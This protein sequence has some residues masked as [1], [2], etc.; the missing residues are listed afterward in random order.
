MHGL[1]RNRATKH[2]NGIYYYLQSVSHRRLLPAKRVPQ[3]F[4][5]LVR[6]LRG[7]RGQFYR[8]AIGNVRT[9]PTVATDGVTEDLPLDHAA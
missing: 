4:R 2:P 3:T 1:T 8:E 9:M 5:L 7:L 6:N